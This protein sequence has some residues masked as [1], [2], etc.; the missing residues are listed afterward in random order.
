M[1][2]LLFIAATVAFFAAAAAVMLACESL[3][4]EEA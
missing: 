2:D 4:K 1:L 3:E